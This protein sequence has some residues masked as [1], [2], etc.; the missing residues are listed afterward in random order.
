LQHQFAEAALAQF[1]NGWAW[2]VLENG[3]LKVM[4]TSNAVN[5]LA[6]HGISLLTCDVWEHAYYLDCQNRRPIS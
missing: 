2:L 6:T 4:K 5:P 1:G 3:R